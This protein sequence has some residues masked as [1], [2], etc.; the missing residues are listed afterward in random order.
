MVDE[1]PITPASTLPACVAS[2][3]RSSTAADKAWDSTVPPF[4]QSNQ[5]Y[6]EL[7]YSQGPEKPFCLRSHGSRQTLPDA[8]RVRLEC[9]SQIISHCLDDLDTP[10]M[11]KLGEKLWRAGPHPEILSLTQQLSMDRRIVVNEDPSVH[12]LWAAVDGI[13]YVKPLPAYLT[14]F[15]FWR[16]LLDTSNSDVNLEERERIRVT[17][18]G[19]LKTYS[20]LIQRRSDF[21]LARRHDLLAS[22]DNI[23]FETFIT[24][25][26]H[27]DAVPQ[28][29]ISA[30][31]RY[32][33][34]Q[35][36]ALNFH[37]ILQLRRWHFNRFESRYGAYFQ[38]L[39][40][41]IL[42][43]FAL[44]SVILSAMQ[45]ILGARQIWDTDNKGLKKTL[46]V[47]EWSAT[48]AIAWS[49]AFG[50]MFVVWWI[51]VSTAEVC[52]RRRM[53]RRFCKRLKEEGVDRP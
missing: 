51:G 12:L 8:P 2:F 28:S 50:L 34:L 23:S 9:P 20:S 18:L 47:F 39:F 53:Q 31:W 16:Y 5:L 1:D 35:L 42:F 40:P 30:R 3:S 46:E 33:I 29:A 14:S 19:F 25:I 10:Q 13:L 38:R 41:I 37:S 45:V 6:E 49:L 7:H 43:I 24:F 11:N 4:P 44:L 32:G 27:F 52:K 21:N 17:A 48:E 15:A 26:S 22:F 36:D